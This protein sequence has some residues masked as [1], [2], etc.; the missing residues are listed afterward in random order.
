METDE[1]EH[2]DLIDHYAAVLRDKSGRQVIWDILSMC[3]L[4]HDQFTGNSQSFHLEGKRAIGLELLGRLGDVEATAYPE[5]LLQFAK[6]EE[7]NGTNNS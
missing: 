1:K 5:L 6:E 3:G 2:D 7:Y 4:Y